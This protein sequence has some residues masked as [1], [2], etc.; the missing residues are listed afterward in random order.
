M[1]VTLSRHREKYQHSCSI[2]F[3][4]SGVKYIAARPMTLNNPVVINPE[5]FPFTNLCPTLCSL[6]WV[7]VSCSVSHCI[8]SSP[9]L[10]LP[11]RRAS[12]LENPI[13]CPDLSLSSWPDLV[14]RVTSSP[15]TS[16]VRSR[17]SIAHLQPPSSLIMSSD[18]PLG[19]GGGDVDKLLLETQSFVAA[20]Q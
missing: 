12:R 10:T 20:N 6:C 15:T 11:A 19:G 8:L 2:P 4:E 18:H 13:Q 9:S 16:Q 17:P 14:R 1:H 5:T 7:L 3:S